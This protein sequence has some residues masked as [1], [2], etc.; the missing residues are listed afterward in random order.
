M[1]E[2]LQGPKQRQ[3]GTILVHLAAYG[4]FIILGVVLLG[5]SLVS[6]EGRLK[7]SDVE[8]AYINVVSTG[9]TISLGDDAVEEFKGIF[10]G[11]ATYK[12]KEGD[13]PFTNYAI[14]I[15][16]GGKT[17]FVSVDQVTLEDEKGEYDLRMLPDE[18][19][20]FKALLRRYDVNL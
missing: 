12:R 3:P 17:L 11:K 10:D 15:S 1:G 16:A 13:A 20:S 14:T 19:T 7:M 8:S 4:I 6:G 2:R 18:W 9:E 5:Y